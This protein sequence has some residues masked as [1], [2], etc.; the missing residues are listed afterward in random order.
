LQE[1]NLQQQAQ[2]KVVPKAFVFS[3]FFW[4]RLACF[5]NDFDYAGVPLHYANDALYNFQCSAF[6]LHTYV[7]ASQWLHIPSWGLQ[8]W[9]GGQRKSMCSARICS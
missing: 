8:E 6:V 1:Q 3:T 5:G 4:T 9:Q 2:G 7:R